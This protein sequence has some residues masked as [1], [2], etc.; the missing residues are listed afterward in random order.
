MVVV[1]VIIE[2]VIV[3]IGILVDIIKV[4]ILKYCKKCLANANIILLQR[5]IVE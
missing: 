3:N 5:D 1:V 2:T 4:N